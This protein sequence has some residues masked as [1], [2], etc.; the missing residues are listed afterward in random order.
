MARTTSPSFAART[1]SGEEGLAYVGQRAEEHPHLGDAVALEPVHEGVA[2]LQGLALATQRGVFPL[3]SPPVGPDAELLV[4]LYVAVG[5][6]EERA[7][8]PEEPTEARMVSDHR[9][10]RTTEV[11]DEVVSEDLRK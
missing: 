1:R 10:R 7:D 4:E 8:D 2:R 5:G 6:F 9:V 3:G 11:E